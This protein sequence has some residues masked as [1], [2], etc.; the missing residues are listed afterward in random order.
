M[1]SENSPVTRLYDSIILGRPVAVLIC[2]F[3][4][5]GVLGLYAGNFRIEASP[6]TLIQ[7]DDEDYLYHQE[8]IDRYGFEDFLMIAYTPD[9]GDLL[10]EK[11]LERIAGL[12]DDIEAID[13]VESVTSLLDVPLLESP[14]MPLSELVGNVRTLSSPG[15]NLELAAGELSTS[16]VYKNLLVSPDLST[17]A[18]QINM[19]SDPEYEKLWDRRQELRQKAAEQGLSAAEKKERD[20]V[21]TE[22]ENLWTR[23]EQERAGVISDIRSVMDDHDEGAELF[24]GGIS[25][26][27]NDL[28]RFIK[29]DLKVYGS[30]V[31]LFLALVLWLV[32]RRVRWVILPLMSCAFSALAMVG[33]MGFFGWRVTVVSSNFISLQLIIT[34]AISIHLVV[35][36]REL[37]RS[38]PERSHADLV[39]Q[40]VI[41][42]RIPCFYAVL[43]T[44]AGFGSLIFADIRPVQTFGWMMAAGILVSLVVT[45]I[46]FPAAL[47]L[48]KK[49]PCP[50]G[51]ISKLALPRLL[52]GFT[53]S[54]GRTIMVIS[55]AALLLSAAGISR[56]EVENAF[57][58]Y[59]KSSTEIS[60]GMKVIDRKLGGTT[61]LDVIIDFNGA[62]EE[63]SSGEPA[64]DDELA[65]ESGGDDFG[66]DD[67]GEFGEFEEEEDPAKYWFTPHRLSRIEDA[68]DYLAGQDH[69]GKVLSLATLN[70]VAERITDRPLDSFE[71]SLL[72]NG[73]PEEYRQMLVSPFA[74]PEHNQARIS[75]RVIDS[76]PDLRRGEFL[77]EI[78]R[79]F[80]E[81]AGFAEE[82][83]NLTG[84]LVLYNDV[85]QSLFDSQIRTLG[86]VLLA[87]MAMF[88][89]LFRSVKISLLAIFPNILSAGVVLGVMGWMGLPLDIMTI[90]IASI[91]IGI[92]VDDTIHYIH[93][94]GREFAADRD[95]IATMH[96]CHSSIGYAMYYTS[97]AIIIGF[98]ILA[99]S[100]FIPTIIFGI[101]TGL[102]MLIA[103]V[104]SLTLLP[105]LII[106]A[107]PFGPENG[108]AGGA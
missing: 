32:F 44:I 49:A 21:A 108:A 107:K 103:L 53:A 61:P 62:G 81:Q 50:A 14:P 82:N 58:D 72:F 64:G 20:S 10:S 69:V 57:I 86:L 52:S 9:S 56:L 70:K 36:Y 75:L 45:F 27:A 11:V 80:T 40:M 39:R 6:D 98:S 93:R 67:F 73:F 89:I 65:D 30:G 31:T 19:D 87:L 22:I 34:M 77:D 26:V 85:L 106:W 91:S 54:R 84:M 25:M 23:V 76:H 46:F 12:R 33:L 24:L 63:S 71:L 55:A 15:I 8:I 74:S 105:R 29:N 35:R 100:N 42:M 4:F 59:F 90:T 99:T 41:D 38:D 96:R 51:G 83:V 47:V 2:F 92:A 1:T 13:G 78:S 102:A 7:Q 88:L 18:L 97:I 3:L 104:S 37:I 43:T 48:F 66:G 101:F 79:G 17:T 16:P 5:L 28:M 94:F 60:Q 95:Y 68:H